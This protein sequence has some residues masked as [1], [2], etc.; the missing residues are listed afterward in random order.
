MGASPSPA[1]ECTAEQLS[2]VAAI[3]AADVRM[4][5][6]HFE[7]LRRRGEADVSMLATDEMPKYYPSQ[8]WD[9]VFA[10]AVYDFHFWQENVP[11]LLAAQQGFAGTTSNSNQPTGGSGQ[12]SEPGLSSQP[13]RK[14]RTRLP[15]SARVDDRTEDGTYRKNRSGTT[16][17]SDYQEGNC[18]DRPGRC[19]KNSD[20][21]HQCAKCLG[22]HPAKS[23]SGRSLR[24]AP[25]ATR[26]LANPRRR[27][28]TLVLEGMG[29]V[30]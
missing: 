1:E 23:C 11:S 30:W 16:L 18:V 12:A 5:Q 8:P 9:W 6:E 21:A 26:G 27:T 19:P 25:R 17:C 20:W 22:N 2:A 24:R 7:R 14:K 29:S 15:S 10:A 3:Y 13:T 28:E 4:R